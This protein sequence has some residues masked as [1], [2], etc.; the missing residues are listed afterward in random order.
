MPSCTGEETSNG[1][2]ADADC[3]A[4][5]VCHEA[6]C[7]PPSKL[8]CVEGGTKAPSLSALPVTLDLG[9]VSGSPVWGTIAIE[10]A[11]TC[12]LQIR[13]ARM[14]QGTRITCPSCDASDPVSVLPG[15]RHSIDVMGTVG[16][17]GRFEDRL[18]LESSDPDRPRVEIP[19]SLESAGPA[20]LVVS[21]VIVDFGYVPPNDARVETVQV[22][23]GAEG[24]SILR[25]ER[26][27]LAGSDAFALPSRP[28]DV[29]LLPARS[30]PSQRLA[31]DVRFA[32]V[33]DAVHT[34]T[35]TI[36]SA[37]GAP[38]EVRLIAAADPPDIDVAPA[39]VDLGATLVGDSVSRRITIQNRGL[40]PLQPSARLMIGHPDLSLPRPVGEIRPGGV[41][42]IDV[43]YQ[44]T[45]A[46]SVAD[47][48]VIASNDPDERSIT[49]PVGG[50]ASAVGRDVVAVEL[51]FENDSDSAL[52]RDLRDVDLALESPAGQICGEAIQ[53]PSWAAYGHPRWSASAP[54]ENPERIVLPDAM[55]DGRFPVTLSYIEDCATLP[56][57]LTAAVLGIGTDALVDYFSDGSVAIDAGELASAVEETCVDRKDPDARIRVTINGAA[58]AD[59][60]VDLRTKGQ[61]ALAATLIR[62]NGS[63]SVE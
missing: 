21:P 43:F 3:E 8:A 15:R 57:A 18:I 52:D 1:C 32:P 37:A 6:A 35:L 16:P 55:E 44:P 48:V 38:A 39:S 25:I 22:I 2:T 5:R 23:N 24:T 28:V 42:E 36:V 20:V 45:V 56:T 34:A 19:I 12:T 40:S 53:A 29:D 4:G 46:G 30:D 10:N 58:A 17:P 47:A 11:G 59:I 33:A 31:I 51:V 26:V 61:S 27:A 41:F 60:A 50:S 63:F 7:V 13:S 49:I 54:K 62:A 9:V 14:E